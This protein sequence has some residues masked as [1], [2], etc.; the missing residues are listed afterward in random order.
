MPRVWIKQTALLFTLVYFFSIGLV[1]VRAE[2]HAL[3]HEEHASHAKR[4]ASF[5]CAW[6]CA[7]STFVHTPEQI[8]HRRAIV[9]AENPIAETEA[10]PRLQPLSADTIRPPP[11]LRS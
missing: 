9:S 8:L 6:M 10:P 3:R 7:G 11:S 2:G 1:M 5:I 4:H